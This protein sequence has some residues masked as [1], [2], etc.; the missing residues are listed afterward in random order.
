MSAHPIRSTPLPLFAVLM[1]ALAFNLSSW[2]TS[3]SHA[4]VQSTNLS[5]QIDSCGIAQKLDEYDSADCEIHEEVVSGTVKAELVNDRMVRD[6]SDESNPKAMKPISEYK[7]QVCMQPTKPLDDDGAGVIKGNP[8]CEPEAR[9]K[10]VEEVAAKVIEITTAKKAAIETQIA[11]A[12]AL[13]ERLERCEVDK[14]GKPVT[15]DSENQVVDDSEMLKCKMKRAK[16]M[17]REEAAEYYDTEIQPKLEE[18]ASC[19]GDENL[20]GMGGLTIGPKSFGQFGTIGEERKCA[21]QRQ[22]AI[23]LSLSLPKLSGGNRYINESLKDMHVF[24]LFNKETAKLM[25]AG[26][27][28]LNDPSRREAGE[29]LKV[30]Q[31]NWAV[32]KKLRG[33][34]IETMRNPLGWENFSISENLGTD[35]AGYRSDMDA[36]FARV[37]QLH[38]QY[39]ESTGQTTA[40]ANNQIASAVTPVSAGNGRQAR[41]MPSTSYA[42]APGAPQ[43]QPINGRGVVPQ[44]TTNRPLNGSNLVK[45]QLGQQVR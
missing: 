8:D 28:P 25:E 10:T 3:P 16:K 18:M 31:T 12:Q 11:E 43:Q 35:L 40:G 44:S 9:V 45:P 7:I 39:L 17:K 37:A 4:D 23:A 34:S 24:A 13:K 19:S 38:Q 41:G 14:R 6:R 33:H 21:L 5:S 32:Y 22:K 36:S 15:E 20:E 26:K 42:N 30:L 1:G 27:L 2:P 29:K